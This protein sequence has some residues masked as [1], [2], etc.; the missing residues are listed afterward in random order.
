MVQ[1]VGHLTLDFGLGHDLSVRKF[2]PHFRL[3]AGSV[4][5]AWDSLSLPLPCSCLHTFSL[6]FLKINKLKKKKS[7]DEW[8]R[9][10]IVHWEVRS[11]GRR[12]KGSV[13]SHE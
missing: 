5:S 3:C 11:L 6:L 8:H 10:W 4:E 12:G 1:S 2:N 9:G 13:P 7:Q